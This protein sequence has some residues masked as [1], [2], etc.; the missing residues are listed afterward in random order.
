[1]KSREEALQEVLSWLA[2]DA[3]NYD[4]HRQQSDPAFKWACRRMCTELSGR[5]A[6]LKNELDLKALDAEAEEDTV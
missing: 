1:M 6:K 4:H 5:S 3:L 2:S